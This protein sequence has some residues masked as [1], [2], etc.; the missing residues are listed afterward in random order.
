MD[1]DDID[2]YDKNYNIRD[3]D[4]NWLNGNMDSYETDSNFDNDS[5]IEDYNYNSNTDNNWYNSNTEHN[6]WSTEYKSSRHTDRQ[7]NTLLE[8]VNNKLKAL[9]SVDR[10]VTYTKVERKGNSLIDF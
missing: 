5:D 1:Y 7:S 9:E 2:D 3:I 4:N 6:N 10:P 8:L